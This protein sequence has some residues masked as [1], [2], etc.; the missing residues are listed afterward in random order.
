MKLI[1]SSIR[2]LYASLLIMS[3]L[4]VPVLASTETIEEESKYESRLIIE[5]KSHVCV[6][7]KKEALHPKNEFI[8]Y[9]SKVLKTEKGHR[10]FFTY[11]QLC[12]L[13]F[14]E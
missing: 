2:I 3:T 6:K 14:Y 1:S 5:D 9:P 8:S 12:E 10:T 11:L 7:P 13:I 4:S